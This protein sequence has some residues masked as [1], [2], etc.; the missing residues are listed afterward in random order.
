MKERLDVLLTAKGFCS[1]RERA[2]NRILAG[3]ILVNGSVVLKPGTAVSE[4][5]TITVTGEDMRYVG[6]GGY[7]LEKLLTDYAIRL[8]GLRCVDVGASTGGFTDCMLQFGASKVYAIDV[9]TGQLAETLRND[10][11]VVSMEQTNV[12]DVGAADLEGE[13]DFL[14]AD[15]SFISLTKVLP[16]FYGLVRDGGRIACLIKPQFEAGK[17]FVGKH[18]V[19]KDRKAHRNVLTEVLQCAVMLGFGIE[20]LTWSPICGQ[21][22][23]IEYL[24]LAVKNG[25]KSSFMDRMS[26]ERVVDE[27][28]LHHSK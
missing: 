10:S 24:F 21:N 20:G 18:G 23:N 11:R 6:R 19:V 12:R 16:V 4:Q 28:F 25:E 15:V 22:G 2:R 26:I 7:K 3:D 8:D 27:A 13:T 1:S 5:D 9:G 14:A 17:A